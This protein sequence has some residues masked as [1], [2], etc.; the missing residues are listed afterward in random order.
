MHL[1]V[2]GYALAYIT[3]GPPLVD[4]KQPP[5][6][7]LDWE[8]VGSSIEEVKQYALT[9]HGDE[10]ALIVKL[11]VQA[12]EAERWPFAFRMRHEDPPPEQ[13]GLFDKEGKNA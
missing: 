12:E 3:D 10:E 6:F 8:S 7:H 11:T 9:W 5:Q 13:P 1:T 2:T 4:R